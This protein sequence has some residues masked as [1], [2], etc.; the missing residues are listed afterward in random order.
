MYTCWECESEVNQATEICPCCGADL[1]GLGL[2]HDEPRP[3]VPMKKKVMRWGGLLVVMLAA[4]WSFLWFVVPERQGNPTAQA[5]SRAMQSLTDVRAALTSYSTAQ[6]GAYPESLEDLGEPARNAL[7]MAS[8]VNYQIIYMPGPA[9]AN[10][11]ITS[12]TIEARAGNFG[13]R[14]FFTDE[15]GIVRSTKENRPANVQ[16]PPL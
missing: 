14:S 2:N 16:D 1:T 9:N 8:S 4:L 12:Y 5:E 11:T 15:A 6:N 13:F 7:Q 3:Q 10:G